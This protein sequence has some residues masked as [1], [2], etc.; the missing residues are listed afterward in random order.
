MVAIKVMKRQYTKLGLQV[1]FRQ[2]AQLAFATELHLVYS[3]ERLNSI[4]TINSTT[5]LAGYAWPDAK[6]VTVSLVHVAEV[7]TQCIST[8][9]LSQPRLTCLSGQFSYFA[10]YAL[11]LHTCSV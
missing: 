3:A 10:E 11:S 5:K 9:L 8:F 6:S 2:S 4:L 1:N 7:L